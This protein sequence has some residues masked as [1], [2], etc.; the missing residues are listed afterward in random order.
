MTKEE[1]LKELRN[2]RNELCMKCGKYHESYK[3]AC[4]DCRYN[5]EHMKKWEE[6]ENETN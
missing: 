1:L 4:D 2:C 3:G 5:F 6:A